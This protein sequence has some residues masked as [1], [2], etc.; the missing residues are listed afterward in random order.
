MYVCAGV[1]GYKPK[2]A[3]RVYLTLL[4]VAVRDD[5]TMDS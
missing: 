3:D 5:S 4:H 2:A 1:Y